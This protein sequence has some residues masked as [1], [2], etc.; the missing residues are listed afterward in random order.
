M[1][2]LKIII[3]EELPSAGGSR[4]CKVQGRG[5]TQPYPTCREVA[6]ETRNRIDQITLRQPYSC[7]KAANLPHFK[8]S[9]TLYQTL[10]SRQK[11]K[12]KNPSMPRVNKQ[13]QKSQFHHSSCSKVLKYVNGKIRERYIISYFQLP[14]NKEFRTATSFSCKDWEKDN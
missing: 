12:K 11:K 2:K 1:F 14:Q 9:Q 3:R 10:D 8:S 13:M 6:S 7:T 4:C 5:R